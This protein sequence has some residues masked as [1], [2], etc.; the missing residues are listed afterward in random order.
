LL[1]KLGRL[2]RDMGAYDLAIA[3]FYNVLNAA[4]RVDQS[5]FARY[6]EFSTEAQ[7]EIADTFM[8][9]GDFQQAGRTYSLLDRLD[10]P[11][12]KKVEAQFQA[13]YCG[14]LSGDYTGTVTAGRRFL[15]TNGDTKYAAQCHY[16]LSVALKALG[17]AQQAADETLT[18]LRM[19]KTVEKT[20]ADTW[21]YWQRKTGNQLANGFYQEGDF[22]R[23]LTLYQAMAKLSDDPAWQWPVIY[24]VGLCFERLRLPDRAAE[25]YHFILDEARKLQTAGKPL[26]EDLTELNHMAD[27]RSQHLE[28]QQGAEAQLNDLL[29]NRAPAD[30]LSPVVTP[31]PASLTQNP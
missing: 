22:V 14:F 20:D 21:T 31:D 13:V 17:Q 24:Q 11:P 26:D 7:F 10:L 27:W 16:I 9:S 18:L 12:D 30:D 15:E 29:G 19:E 28:W 1:L 8:D 6:Q 2:Y 5:E 23:A 3:R 25:A 4:L